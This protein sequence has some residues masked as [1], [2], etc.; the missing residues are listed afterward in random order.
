MVNTS[1]IIKWTA[2]IAGA[3]SLLYGATLVLL[4]YMPGMTC[5]PITI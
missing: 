5:C 2:A 1:N 3:S 4:L